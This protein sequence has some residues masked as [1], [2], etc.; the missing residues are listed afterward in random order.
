MHA[1]HGF[2]AAS[3]PPLS[4]AERF[5]AI[6]PLRQ[7]FHFMAWD[8]DYADL[9]EAELPATVDGLGEALAAALGQCAFVAT[10]YFGGEGQ[11]AAKLWDSD[12]LGMEWAAGRGPN[13][14]ICSALRRLGVER[15]PGT[16][17]EFE[18]VGLDDFRSNDAFAESHAARR[19]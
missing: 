10:D 8:G 2:I 11:Q 13:G 5:Q 15:T 12:G 17:D 7:G 1:I 4:L 3:A 16:L 18:A 9:E 19:T 14:P 6:G